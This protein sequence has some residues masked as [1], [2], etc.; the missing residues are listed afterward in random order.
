MLMY[1]LNNFKT[2]WNKA[3]YWKIWFYI[4]DLLLW[5]ELHTYIIFDYI[6]RCDIEKYDRVL[7]RDAIR[8]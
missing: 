3:S 1:Y 8:I 2:I 7:I 6:I 4:F 5:I